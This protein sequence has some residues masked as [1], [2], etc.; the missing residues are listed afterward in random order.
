MSEEHTCTFD[1]KHLTPCN[2]NDAMTEK[3]FQC[4]CGR[5]YT[6]LLVQ[7]EEKC[8]HVEVTC[9]RSFDGHSSSAEIICRICRKTWVQGYSHANYCHTMQNLYSTKHGDYYKF[10]EENPNSKINYVG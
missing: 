6:I 8:T 10:K 3:R 9:E 4:S 5:V 2:L 7:T 1:T